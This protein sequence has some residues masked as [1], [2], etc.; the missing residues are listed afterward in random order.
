MS[1]LIFSG[2]NKEKLLIA[3]GYPTVDKYNSWF[4]IINK[5]WVYSKRFVA[6][7]IELSSHVK[8]YHP[9]KRALSYELLFLMPF[10]SLDKKIRNAKFITQAIALSSDVALA[11]NS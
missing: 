3:S 9:N 7:A 2:H 10:K 5:K 6:P 11:T 8:V 1:L 4:E